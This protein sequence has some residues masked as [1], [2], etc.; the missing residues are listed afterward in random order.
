VITRL[1]QRGKD[2]KDILGVRDAQCGSGGGWAQVISLK[3]LE[4]EQG[5]KS[6]QDQVMYCTVIL[7][8][9]LT[10]RG[11]KIF[12]AC[13]LTLMLT[14]GEYRDTNTP[15]FLLHIVIILISRHCLPYAL[16]FCTVLYQ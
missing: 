7:S 15:P 11:E 6:L 12:R 2:F 14:E 13:I 3:D 10:V 16:Q 4:W 1:G 9:M 5:P 8:K